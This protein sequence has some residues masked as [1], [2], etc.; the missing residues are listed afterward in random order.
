MDKSRDFIKDE[1]TQILNQIKRFEKYNYQQILEKRLLY[2][3]N[4]YNYY[5]FEGEE[6]DESIISD[7]CLN[8]K[9]NVNEFIV[10]KDETPLIFILHDQNDAL[11]FFK[12]DIIN[13][14]TNKNNI[15][16]SKKK[17]KEEFIKYIKIL[18]YIINYQDIVNC[19]MYPK[20]VFH[21]IKTPEYN[22]VI[23]FND[24]VSDKDIIEI[25]ENTYKIKI[26]TGNKCNIPKQK[27]FGLF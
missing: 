10:K 6:F 15:F 18:N 3:L 5:N 26:C 4:N 2:F 21:V 12:Q 22:K 23:H 27:L 8:K 24:V 9:Q 1:H 17:D 7:I 14:L 16:Y 11:C 13:M 19:I 25:E 20:K